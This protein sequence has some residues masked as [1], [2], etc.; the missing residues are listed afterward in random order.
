MTPIII[1]HATA[2]TQRRKAIAVVVIKQDRSDAILITVH[3]WILSFLWWITTQHVWCPFL[4]I[5]HFL[6]ICVLVIMECAPD[7][8]SNIIA[9]VELPFVNGVFRVNSKHLGGIF[10]RWPGKASKTVGIRWIAVTKIVLE[11]VFF[12]VG[13]SCV[14]VIPP[15]C[16]PLYLLTMFAFSDRRTLTSVA[17]I[18][19]HRDTCATVSAGYLI[20]CALM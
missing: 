12:P 14:S 5:Y 4:S 2:K 20:T 17:V 1:T 13:P 9:G 3:E 8:M 11:H 6:I 18:L 10:H 16:R 7:C 15:K 19:I